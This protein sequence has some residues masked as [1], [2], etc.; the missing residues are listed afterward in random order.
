MITALF[1]AMALFGAGF[2]AYWGVAIVRRGAP[3]PGW[4]RVG[5]GFITNFL[6]TLGIGSFAT[7]TSMYK[8]WGV[9]D[10]ADIPGTMMVGHT[11]PTLVEAFIFIAVVQVDFMTMALLIAASVVGSWLGARFVSRWPRR[12]IR[13]GMGSA[14]LLAA[15]V[16]IVK[17][18]HWV[19]SGGQAIGLTGSALVAGIVGNM[20]F[21]ALMTLGIGLYAPCMIM[22][23][24][25][26]MNPRAAFPIMTGSCAMLMPVGSA[27]FIRNQRYNVKAAL[28]LTLGGIPGVLLAAFVVKSLPLDVV[29]WLV[30]IV[31]L[32]TAAMLLRAAMQREPELQVSAAD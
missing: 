30:V 15:M 21:G 12:Q 25:L 13:I 29:Y 26:G 23:A 9:V 4:V 5:I 18:L 28:G 2:L 31:V 22:V 16:M 10:D 24:L 11:P 20:A 17:Q 6:D 32:Y 1:T 7:T 27:P 3:K 19:S 14:L 8:L